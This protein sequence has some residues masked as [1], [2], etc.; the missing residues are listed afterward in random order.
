MI[1][2]VKDA[3]TGNGYKIS[4]CQT[5]CGHRPK[6]TKLSQGRS[7]ISGKGGSYVQCIKVWGFD[8]LNLSHFS[9]IPKENEIIWSHQTISFS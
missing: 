4:I 1:L 9:F 7:R 8:L 3:D 5:Q 2:T 6:S